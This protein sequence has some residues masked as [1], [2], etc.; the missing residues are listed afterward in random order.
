MKRPTLDRQFSRIMLRYYPVRLRF[1][2]YM[3]RF[4]VDVS[5]GMV[6]T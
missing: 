5:L 1:S 3:G 2:G 6:L 4:G